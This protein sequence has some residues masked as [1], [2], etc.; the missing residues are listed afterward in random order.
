MTVLTVR[1]PLAGV[2]VAATDVPD[3]VFAA[4]ML[5]PGVAI[6]P[7]RDAEVVVVAPVDGTVLAVHP[8]AFV[9]VS[10]GGR[11]VLV[12]LGVDTVELQ[13]TGFTVLAAAGQEVAAGDVVVTWRPRDVE[14]GGRSPVCPVVALEAAA[15]GITPQA[16]PGSTVRAGDPLFGWE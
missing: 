8:H 14:A 16:T 4:G 11:A 6:D 3:P 12:H 10:P 7:A 15:G 5:G 13:G 1:A 2:V 9:I